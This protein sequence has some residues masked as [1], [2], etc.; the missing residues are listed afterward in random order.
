M[1]VASSRN[2]TSPLRMPLRSSASPSLASPSS[3]PPS[4][5]ARLWGNHNSSPLL[6][7][8]K[9]SLST[10]TITL[11][12]SRVARTDSPSGSVPTTLLAKPPVQ[13][14]F[15][16]ISNRDFSTFSYDCS[17]TKSDYFAHGCPHFSRNDPTVFN[18]VVGLFKRRS[19]W[20]GPHCRY[21]NLVVH[22]HVKTQYKDG[23]IAIRCCCSHNGVGQMAGR[24]LHISMG[25]GSETSL[26][27][28][29]YSLVTNDPKF[30]VDSGN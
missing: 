16:S 7:A 8:P 14:N 18:I 15:E 28:T 21:P 30:T 2:C 3:G 20:G 13:K 9:A 19:L 23:N 4:S 5:A 24:K 25:R 27:C 22:L 12:A 17:C 10:P 26:I 11:R 29:E 1:L 6:L